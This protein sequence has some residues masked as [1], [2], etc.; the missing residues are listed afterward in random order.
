MR[1]QIKF[2]FVDI[3]IGFIFYLKIIGYL[4]DC[5]LFLSPP[6]FSF[7]TPHILSLLFPSLLYFR[8]FSFLLSSLSF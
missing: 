2:S 3:D 1:L 8:A 5:F 6:F 7:P 4:I